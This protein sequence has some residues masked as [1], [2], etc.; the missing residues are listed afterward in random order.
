VRIA[1]P[2]NVRNDKG[3]HGASS[4]VAANLARKMG[5]FTVVLAALAAVSAAVATSGSPVS[6]APPAAQF[7]RAAVTIIDFDDLVTGGPGGA[8]GLVTVNSQYASRGITFNNVAA[9]DYSKGASALP[10]FAHSGPVGIEQCIGVEFCTTPIAA[11]FGLPQ[12][13]IQV[14]VGFSFRLSEAVQ[15]QLKALNAAGG[16]VGTA[17]ATLPANQAVTPIRTR[18]KV[19]AGAASITQFQVSIPGGFDNAL[20]VDDVE[21]TAEG[22]PPPCAATSIPN[23][24]LELPTDGQLVRTNEF[25]L[26]G[27]IGN[28]GAP[29]ES[30]SLRVEGGTANNLFPTAIG[31]GGGPFGPVLFSGLLKPGSQKIIVSAKNCLGTGTAQVGV[32]W[33]RNNAPLSGSTRVSTYDQLKAALTTCKQNVFV[34]NYARINLAAI[35]D[36]RASA[37]NYVLHVPDGVTLAGGRSSTEQGGL[38]YM[39]RRL[40][41]QVHMLDLGSN[42]RVTGLRL[43]GYDLYATDNPNNVET[44]G[45]YI[46]AAQDILIE[47]NEISGWPNAGIEVS[48]ALNDRA[49]LNRIRISRNYIHNNVS[50]RGNGYGFV[51]GTKGFAYID[52]NVFDYN[53]HD[54]AGDGKPGTGY[55]ATL[56]FVLTSGPT[57]PASAG[58]RFYNQHFDMHGSGEG[59]EHLGGVAGQYVLIARN[60]IRGDQRYGGFAGVGQRTRPAFELRGTP[61]DAAV[62][63]DNAVA[64]DDEDAAVRI[65]GVKRETLKSDGKLVVRRNKYD[66]DTSG[67][68]AVGDFDGDGR[69]D[70]FQST[71]ALWAYS[72]S[73]RREWHFLNDSTLLLNAL[74]FGDFDGDDKRDVFSQNGTQWR[75]SY[76]GTTEWRALPSGSNLDMR[77]YRFADFDGDR[78][79]DIFR[80]NGSH[81]YISSGGATPWQELATSRLKVGELR[82]GDF[83]GDGKTDV[84]SLANSQWSVSYG[85]RSAWR[86]LNKRLSSTLGELVFADFN[87]DGR[88]DV[89]R[90]GLLKW[91][92][93]WG[94]VSPWRT[95]K[96]IVGAPFRLML[97][98]DFTGDRRADVLQRAKLANQP[99]PPSLTRFR[100][101]S[102]GVGP[103]GTWSLADMR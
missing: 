72:P 12:R 56:N 2:L 9:V 17:S 7:A 43:R 36:Q 28:G 40:P 39:S 69:A 81:W 19:E 30:A 62:F 45:L 79:T 86:R 47:N 37:P 102:G 52:R 20:A 76:G 97:F 1:L 55:V 51:V 77:T 84:F 4:M 3:V 70:V 22:P 87:G 83:D 90:G 103:L 18:L 65:E 98:A 94:G 67:Q 64:H 42:T 31:P 88:T 71:G 75:V 91:E 59:P 26:K 80:A 27:T 33:C 32:Y 25:S 95:L 46:G 85:G 16:I 6:R 14:W 92:V 101:S 34:E 68:L 48:G 49:N 60:T 66:L 53:R 57:C 23:V 100:L 63:V 15:V 99:I 21:F 29:I 24:S 89:A 78:K 61:A 41:K 54:V 11:T 58:R 13:R 82:F 74:A 44:V 35:S 50:C 96:E 73:G 8:G 10:S 93:S 38:L 5:R